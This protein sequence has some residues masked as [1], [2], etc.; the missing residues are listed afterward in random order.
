MWGLKGVGMLYTVRVVVFKLIASR[1]YEAV[2][3]ASCRCST[4]SSPSS[5]GASSGWPAGPLRMDGGCRA[6]HLLL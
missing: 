4:W 6:P 2:R 3:L 1:T 5:S